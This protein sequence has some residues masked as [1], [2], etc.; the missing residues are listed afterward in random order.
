M[1]QNKRIENLGPAERIIN[2]LLAYTDH[3]Y[4]GRPG[5]AYPD[6]KQVTGVRWE[7]AVTE[8]VEG[9]KVL[10][11]IVGKGRKAT[12]TKIGDVRE[13]KKIVLNGAVIGEYREPGIF[14]EVAAWMYNQIAE[15]WK[16]DNEF[17]ARWASYAFGQEHR[18][19]KVVL[20]AF[21]LC[22][23]R[24]GDPVLDAG[25]LAFYD[26]DFRDVGEAMAL[27]YDK[28]GKKDMSPK[29]LL[30]VYEVLTLP[31]VAA[32]NRELMFGRSARNP[33]LGRWEKVVHKWLQYRE[34]NPKLLAGL[35]KAGFKS[36]IQDLVRISGYKPQGPAFFEAL[37]WKQR[38]AKDGRRTIL[39]ITVSAAES[40][41]DLTE[42][43]IC[44]RISR[45]K[46]NWKKAAS[47]LPKH[48]GVTRAIMMA[49]I[50]AGSFS[51][52]DL[53]IAM[54]TLEDLG[55]L[56]VQEV[57]ERIDKAVRE[58][59]DMRAAN[60]ALRLRN[61]DNQDKAQE[62]A[63]NAL[64][65]AVVEVT[66]NLR[67]YFMVDISG[68]MEQSIEEAKRH[69][70]RFLQAFPPEQIHVAVFNTAGREVK[71]PH[72]SAAGVENAFRGIRA[73]GGTD[74][75][76]GVQA[77]QHFKPKPDEDVLFFFVGDEEA[78]GFDNAV[79]A[80][81]L[82]PMAFGLVKIR[83]SPHVCVQGSAAALGI[84]CFLVDEATFADPYAIPRTIR[85]LIAATPVNRI[86]GRAP[87]AP[88]QTL[89]DTILKTELLAKPAWAT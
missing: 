86:Q 64:K 81:G 30:R 62:A 74:Y 88:R 9:K 71:I 61:K 42:E 4:H 73:G 35:T 10:N 77:L 72:A 19:L 16:L 21:M 68:S 79:R 44:E 69:I 80:S 27:V 82:N 50:E 58:A 63:D 78:N 43:Q 65:K 3:M 24:K 15:V 33:H 39:D 53:I 57:K 87:A 1:D 45:D 55:L 75:G 29:M 23:S 11:R 48:L 89:V 84:P 41:N 46:P 26:E 70:A 52:K 49:A 31:Q 17:A 13:D 56:Q 22:Q 7:Y 54:P 18:D 59:E 20:A 2:A 5:I 76:S 14:P 60:V 34:E 28:A 85:N 36:T 40:W 66:K 8:E 32:V 25:K 47:L 37:R 6:P 83:N 67:V 38:Q 51:S 12:K